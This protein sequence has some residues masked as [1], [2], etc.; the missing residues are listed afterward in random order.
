MKNLFT[1]ALILWTTNVAAYDPGVAVFL[2]EG[3][4]P[5]AVECANAI[6]KGNLVASTFIDGNIPMSHKAYNGFLFKIRID[7]CAVFCLRK[8]KLQ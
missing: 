8:Q 2:G 6:K 5:T 1:V 7:D 4:K 3:Q